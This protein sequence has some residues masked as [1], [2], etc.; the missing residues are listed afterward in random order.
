MCENCPDMLGHFVLTGKCMNSFKLNLILQMFD[1]VNLNKYLLYHYKLTCTE[2]S[3]AMLLPALL[4]AVIL[5]KN[6]SMVFFMASASGLP[7]DD[8]D[9]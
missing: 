5:C 1:L 6:V 8:K 3:A 2:A 4:T 7:V 9:G